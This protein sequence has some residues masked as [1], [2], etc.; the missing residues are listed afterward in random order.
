[1]AS[2]NKI[3]IK[4]PHCSSVFERTQKQVNVVVRRS[5]VWACK[6]CVTSARN[7]MS[8]RR[9]GDKRT[10][11]SGYV[12]V[13]TADGW[14][15]EHVAV[16]EEAIGRELLPGE[17]VHHKNEIKDDNRLENLE[18]MRFD[19]HTVLHHTGLKRSS[20]T[21]ARIVRA[22]RSRGSTKLSESKIVEVQELRKNGMSQA[23]IAK[24]LDVSQMT[25]CRALSGKT[26]R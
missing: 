20:E 8:A 2:I 9:I 19:A 11:K 17:M 16:M 26:W 4:C 10:L 7:S 6:S 1:M 12:E 23:A 25:I 15:R 24:A 22:A 3:A 18:L 21:R 14:V 13:K 5:G